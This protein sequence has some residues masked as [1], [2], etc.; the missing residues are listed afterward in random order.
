MSAHRC[1]YVHV[2]TADT[3]TQ[4]G[5]FV[6]M[7]NAGVPV[8][9]EH[10]YST[11]NP[12]SRP[13]V[14]FITWGDYVKIGTTTVDAGV[15]MRQIMYGGTVVPGDVHGKPMVVATIDGG[16]ETEAVLHELLSSHRAD[17]EWFRREG[18]VS[19]LLLWLTMRARTSMLIPDPTSVAQQEAILPESEQVPVDF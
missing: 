1:A 5:H 6:E 13:V 12:P 15:R 18:E 9:L 11:R 7:D 3:I 19:K 10:R 14:Y 8:C 4:C 2:S 17:G 16:V